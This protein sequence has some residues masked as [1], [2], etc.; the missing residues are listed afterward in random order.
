MKISVAARELDV[1][2]IVFVFDVWASRPIFH[3]A[4]FS[5]EIG[6]MYLVTACGIPCDGDRRDGRSSAIALPP[7]H[8]A[9]IGRPCATC[10]PELRMQ[11][12]LFA[13]RPAGETRHD[14]EALT[15]ADDD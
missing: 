12:S 11:T 5:G 13:R 1:G 3:R 2:G 6:A 10:W 14:Q 9:R 4:D 8:A 7:R 15:D